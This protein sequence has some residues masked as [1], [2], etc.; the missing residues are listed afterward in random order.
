MC[1]LACQPAFL[2]ALIIIA[3]LVPLAADSFD[4]IIGDAPWTDRELRMK[5][6]ISGLRSAL[7]RCQS[8]NFGYM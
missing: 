4:I 2:F 8:R 6:T 7:T 3:L 5:A 1:P